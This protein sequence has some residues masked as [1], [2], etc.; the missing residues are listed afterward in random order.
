MNLALLND[1]HWIMCREIAQ[2]ILAENNFELTFVCQSLHK[3]EV[4]IFS[5]MFSYHMVAYDKIKLLDNSE[6]LFEVL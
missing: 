3:K 2:P 1:D 4:I 6:I 5:F